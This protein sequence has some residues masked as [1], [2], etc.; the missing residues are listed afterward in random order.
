L[1]KENEPK[2]KTPTFTC[3]NGFARGTE[4]LCC[5]HDSHPAQHAS[6]EPPVHLTTVLSAYSPSK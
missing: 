5:R 2:E 3:P 1:S 4:R 6:N